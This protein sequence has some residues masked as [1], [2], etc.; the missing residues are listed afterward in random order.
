MYAIIESCGKQYKVAEG[1]TLYALQDGIVKFSKRNK[2]TCVNILT[3]NN[4]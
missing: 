1:D 4:I 2:K 3:T